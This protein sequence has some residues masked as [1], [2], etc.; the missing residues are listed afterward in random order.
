MKFYLNGSEIECSPDEY[1]RLIDLGVIN[2]GN[3]TADNKGVPKLQTYPGQQSLEDWLKEGQRGVVAV[4]GCQ[5]PGPVVYD[6]NFT[7]DTKTISKPSQTL[8]VNNGTTSVLAADKCDADESTEKSGN[9][10]IK[11]TDN[12]SNDT[13]LPPIDMNT[14]SVDA[15]YIVKQT[16]INKYVAVRMYNEEAY[17]SVVKLDAVRFINE[18][19]ATNYANMASKATGNNFKAVKFD[20]DW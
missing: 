6:Q 5:I 8:M 19:A 9:V 2:N 12:V 14:I 10:A 15:S 17:L 1:K 16:D 13:P 11:I 18:E 7:C 20:Y 3:S 4:Y